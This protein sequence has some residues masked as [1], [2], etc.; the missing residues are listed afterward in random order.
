MFTGVI[1]RV[2]TEWIPHRLPSIRPAG[3]YKEHKLYAIFIYSLW[4]LET[5]EGNLNYLLQEAPLKV[6]YFNTNAKS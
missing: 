6:M 5:L 4:L 1:N 2:R 3:H